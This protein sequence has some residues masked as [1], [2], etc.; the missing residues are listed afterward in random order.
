MPGRRHCVNLEARTPIVP[1]LRCRALVVGARRTLGSEHTIRVSFAVVSVCNSVAVANLQS[2]VDPPSRGR[3]LRSLFFGRKCSC[4][5]G[6]SQCR[7]R[8]PRETRHRARL[9][10]SSVPAAL[11]LVVGTEHPS[12]PGFGQLVLA[13]GLAIRFVGLR[14]HVGSPDVNDSRRRQRMPGPRRPA[15]KEKQQENHATSGDL[16]PPFVKIEPHAISGRRP[17]ELEASALWG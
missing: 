9:H 6:E 8:D 10:V 3:L 5:I 17:H 13:A 7:L 16:Q 14:V 12:P 1:D 15:R 11:D 4:L 2:E